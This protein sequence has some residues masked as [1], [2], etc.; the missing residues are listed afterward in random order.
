MVGYSKWSKV[1]HI[2][3]PFDVKHG[4]AFGKLVKKIT[5]AARGR[6]AVGGILYLPDEKEAFAAP[7]SLFDH[8][9]EATAAHWPKFC[10][11]FNDSDDIQNIYSNFD[12]SDATLARLAA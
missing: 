12:V 9:D 7:R 6:R 10:E 5:V 2:K 8:A 4:A 1:K 3:G 11:T